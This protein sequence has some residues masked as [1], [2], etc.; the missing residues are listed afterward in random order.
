MPRA[1]VI[2]TE[3]P[4]ALGPKRKVGAGQQLARVHEGDGD[5]CQT[6]FQESMVEVRVLGMAGGRH[7]VTKAPSQRWSLLIEPAKLEE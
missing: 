6:D 7:K 1:K 5:Q 3:D 2:G 4:G